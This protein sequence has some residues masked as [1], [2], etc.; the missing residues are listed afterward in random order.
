MNLTELMRNLSRFTTA[1]RDD[2]EADA[3][4]P[5]PQQQSAERKRVLLARAAELG[6]RNADDLRRYE[7]QQA[8]DEAATRRR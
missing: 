1:Q 7:L 4:V 3:V 6:I 8:V 5:T 2:A